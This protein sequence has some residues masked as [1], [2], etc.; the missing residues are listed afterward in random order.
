MVQAFFV[1]LSNTVFHFWLGIFAA[2]PDLPG[3]LSLKNEA[4]RQQF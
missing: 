2:V 1:I 3:R 4:V